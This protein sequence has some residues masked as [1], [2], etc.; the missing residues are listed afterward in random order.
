MA[1]YT[2]TERFY[3]RSPEV[4][5]D[6]LRHRGFRE[7]WS[8]ITPFQQEIKMFHIIQNK[9]ALLRKQGEHTVVDYSK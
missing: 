8:I 1:T 3:K 4:V 6:V 9:F 7:E 5:A 2:G